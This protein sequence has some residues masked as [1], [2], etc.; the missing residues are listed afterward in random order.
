MLPVSAPVCFYPYFLLFAALGLLSAEKFQQLGGLSQDRY[1]PGVKTELW[2]AVKDEKLSDSL[3]G[4][5]QTE[6]VKSTNEMKG[7]DMLWRTRYATF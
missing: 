6:K 5:E 4:G 2:T 1:L 7:A 3:S